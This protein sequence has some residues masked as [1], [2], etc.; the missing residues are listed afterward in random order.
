MEHSLRRILPSDKRQNINRKFDDSVAEFFAMAYHFDC[1]IEA[2]PENDEKTMQS[3]GLKFLEDMNLIIEN[4]KL[5]EDEIKWSML[6]IRLDINTEYKER[7]DND[8]KLK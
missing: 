5:Y 2:V 1:E 7:M 8:I 4:A 3:L 6:D